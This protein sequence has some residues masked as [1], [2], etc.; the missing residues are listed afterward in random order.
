MKIK[1]TSF[2]NELKMIYGHSVAN[3]SFTPTYVQV[4]FKELFP[5]LTY[6]QDLY[7]NG[8]E[9]LEIGYY[10]KY[11][12]VYFNSKDMIE[13]VSKTFVKM[14][15]LADEDTINQ[16][17]NHE[18]HYWVSKTYDA[19]LHKG[20]LCFLSSN[21]YSA[22][23]Y[24]VEISED[25]TKYFLGGKSFFLTKFKIIDEILDQSLPLSLDYE[26]ITLR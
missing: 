6:F 23:K 26:L 7:R 4:N 20:D 21:S 13:Y 14:H 5:A 3:S 24:L 22:I 2:S 25:S 8:F 19:Y 12:S 1:P 10:D 17:L 11:F 15:L 16:I 18:D 9:G